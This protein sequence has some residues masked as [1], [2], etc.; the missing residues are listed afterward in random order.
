MPRAALRFR[1]D[2]GPQ[3]AVGPGKI[4]L[5]EAI[6][7]SG[8]LSQA[9]RELKMSYRRAWLLLDSLNGAFTAAV[10]ETSTGGSRGG[11]SRLTPLGEELIRTYRA[12]EAAAQRRAAR[13]FERLARQVQ[14]RGPR[15]RSVSG[16]ARVRRLS[17]RAR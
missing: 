4:S 10:V 1:V 2:F 16:A 14:G 15:A 7:R 6:R 3:L 8:S 13:D 11:G 12:S 5:L 9:A 17:S